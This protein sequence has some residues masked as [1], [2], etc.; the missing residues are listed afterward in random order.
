MGTLNFEQ[1]KKSQVAQTYEIRSTRR[2]RPTARATMGPPIE[3]YK[4]WAELKIESKTV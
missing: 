2:Q 4:N 1:D 3:S